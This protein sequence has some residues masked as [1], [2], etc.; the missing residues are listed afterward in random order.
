M[1]SF[2]YHS[3][4]NISNFFM[5]YSFTHGFVGG[6]FSLFFSTELFNFQIFGT[7]LDVLFLFISNLIICDLRIY[8]VGFQFCYLVAL[9]RE[10]IY[11]D[12]KLCCYLHPPNYLPNN[13]YFQDFPIYNSLNATKMTQLTVIK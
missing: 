11:G 5:T 8:S 12:S 2:H 1:L 10:C 9:F 13:V 3:V 6:F 7:F 4:K